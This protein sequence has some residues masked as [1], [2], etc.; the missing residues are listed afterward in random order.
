M[1]SVVFCLLPITHCDSF[2]FI[3]PCLWFLTSDSRSLW[4]ASLVCPTSINTHNIPTKQAV[5]HF[6]RVGWPL[7]NQASN[8][9]DSSSEDCGCFIHLTVGEIF[10]SSVGPTNWQTDRQTGRC[11][12]ATWLDIGSN[13][14][15]S[16]DRWW[17]QLC[18]PFPPI[19][20]LCFV[21][22]RQ[23]LLFGSVQVFIVKLK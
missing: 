13:D 5:G 1:H 2:F 3:F 20:A 16:Y 11:S 19:S 14:V 7:T 15:V 12:D 8:A 23:N 9:V 6:D 21:F 22:L 4:M 10:Y 17:S 18:R